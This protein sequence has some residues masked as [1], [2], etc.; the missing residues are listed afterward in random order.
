MRRNVGYYLLQGYIP[1][2]L[3]VILSW[4][5]F[6]IDSEA[7]ADRVY[8]GLCIKNYIKISF[9]IDSHIGI[10]CVLSLTTLT[11]DIRSHIPAV[12]Y[13]T[14]IDYFFIICYLFL[15]ASLIQFTAVHRYLEVIRILII[16]QDFFFSNLCLFFLVSSFNNKWQCDR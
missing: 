7:T 13:F 5:S 14:A 6:W 1:A 2:G 8:I 11:L 9:L 4:I 12:P 10:T 3:I 16:S 15:L